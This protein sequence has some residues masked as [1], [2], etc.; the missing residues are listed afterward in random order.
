MSKQY[1]FTMVRKASLAYR[2]EHGKNPKNL[3]LSENLACIVTRFSRPWDYD[4]DD[5]PYPLREYF[6]SNH[7]VLHIYIVHKDLGKYFNMV[8]DNKDYEHAVVEHHLL[9]DNEERTRELMREDL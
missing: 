6:G 9:V 3:Y 1:F 4:D 8:G 7:C 5:S 2:H